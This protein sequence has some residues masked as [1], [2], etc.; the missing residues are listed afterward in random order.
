V[1][2]PGMFSRVSV[3]Y[4]VHKNALTVPRAA[5]ITEDGESAVYVVKAG[6]AHRA[7]VSLGYADGD[8]VEIT[9]GL[10]DGDMVVTLGQNSL[11]DGTKVAV[12]N[13][14]PQKA[15]AADAAKPTP[16]V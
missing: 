2:A 5:L 3:T 11:K 10:A 13:A 6:V 14:A 12:V 9:H 1:L 15:M 7:A 8:K 4:D 16:S